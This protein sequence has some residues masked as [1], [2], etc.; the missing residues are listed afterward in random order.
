MK[1]NTILKAVI[2]SVI[3]LTLLAFSTEIFAA[4]SASIETNSATNIY[5]NQATLNGYFN[6]GSSSYNNYIWFQWGTSS[7]YG[8]TTSQ[9]ALIASGSFS[10]IISNLSSNTTYHYRSVVQTS[11]GI[12]YGEDMNFVSSN[13]GS[14]STA[15]IYSGNASVTTS[16]KVI[17]LT[18]GN[19]NWSTSVNAKPGDVLTF[20]ITMQAGSK[21]IHNVVIRDAL[22]AG[23]I[24]KGNMTVNASLN[25]GGD[26][27]NGIN[28]GT[29]PANG[30]SI[31]SFQVCVAPS[32][33]FAYG[34]ININNSATITSTETGTQT[35]TASVVVDNAYVSGVTTISTGLTNDIVK[36]S[37]FLPVFLIMLGSWLYFSGRIYIFADW[38]GEKL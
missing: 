4:T 35:T 2:F 38:I 27:S 11:T 29:I 12:I 25:Y 19:L 20:A 36:D 23:L 13:S 22:S 33:S 8:F 16:E 28:I 10:Q 15:V 9:Q 3:C 21:D 1:T 6:A 14:T 30:I 5:S 24:Y 26:I 34:S 18:S 17:N 37:F 32:S 7:G 31:V